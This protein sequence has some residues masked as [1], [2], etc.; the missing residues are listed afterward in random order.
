MTNL[1][2]AATSVYLRQHAS[3]PVDWF[4]WGDEA[5]AEAQQRGVPVFV[6]VGYA[7]CHW[8]HV[9]A[10][11][12]FSD[13]EIAGVLAAGFVSIKVDREERPDVDDALMSAAAA[14]T[15][16]LGWPLSVF[17]TPEGQPFF[18][19]TYFPPTAR[20]GA[21][22]FRDVLDA[23]EV[24]WREQPDA[25][26]A[27]AARLQEALA[28][29]PTRGQNV[30]VE[31]LT[32]ALRSIGDDEDDRYGGL[33]T[34]PKFPH[35]TAILALAD[36]DANLAVGLLDAA[37]GDDAVVQTGQFSHL[38]ARDGG[39]FRYATKRDWSEPHYERMLVDNAQLL[40]A[41]ARLVRAPFG[42]GI[43]SF[44]GEVLALPGGAFA[45]AED[46]ESEINGERVEGGWHLGEGRPRP[47]VDRLVVTSAN[48]L[49][50]EAL[51]ERALGYEDARAESLAVAAAEWLLEHH[52]LDDRLVHASLDGVASSAPANAQDAGSFA[53]GLLALA[54]ATGDA[55]Y[56]VRAREI[57]DAASDPDVTTNTTRTARSLATGPANDSVVPGGPAA[58]AAALYRLHALTGDD[59]YRIRAAD[60][61]DPT[62]AL[63]QPVSAPSTLAVA[64]ALATPPRTLVLIG[65]PPREL[66]RRRGA[67]KVPVDRVDQWVEAGFTLLEGKVH[68]GAYECEG[69]VCKLRESW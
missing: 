14:F 47:D 50:I 37:G 21:P 52:V 13:P 42:A 66:R 19:G 44:L 6:S 60:L 22:A 4:E 12:S 31:T 34:G 55:G 51:A 56:A 5:F 18:A 67:L 16:H 15:Q 49:A 24:A 23:V 61:I 8:C 54:G 35:A 57:L 29:K 41:T 64:I 36:I 7:T 69:F 46:A 27:S 40:L 10:R 53:S 28:T 59:T 9:M 17:L 62:L 3:N 25:A 1:L 32:A 45:T 48:G 65:D 26:R 2:S 30:D 39:F 20:Q 33:G 63:Q 11:E 58:L 38:R 43:V 68:P